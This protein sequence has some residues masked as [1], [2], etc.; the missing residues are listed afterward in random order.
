MFSVT[1]CRSH[2]VTYLAAWIPS[3]ASQLA[4]PICSL[5]AIETIISNLAQE[6][7]EAALD[8]SRDQTEAAGQSSDADVSASLPNG[9]RDLPAGETEAAEGAQPPSNGVLSANENERQRFSREMD[10]QQ[11]MTSD[12]HMPLA[13]AQANHTCVSLTLLVTVSGRVTCT[14][15]GVEGA[16]HVAASSEQ[17]EAPDLPADASSTGASSSPKPPSASAEKASKRPAA[18]QKR[19]KA[20]GRNQQCPCGSHKKY[21]ACCGKQQAGKAAPASVQ[22]S[23]V[24]TQDLPHIATLYV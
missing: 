17:Q 18:V 4:M 23:Q 10:Q 15:Q 1:P 7:E 6:M 24:R 5:Q 9:L 16:D 12:R 3:D 2:P 22:D 13:A 11:S 14:L 8:A 20:V 19:G 21:K